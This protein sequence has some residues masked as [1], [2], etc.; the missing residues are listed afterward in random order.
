MK[1]IQKESLE[2]FWKYIREY[3]SKY[4]VSWKQKKK[5]L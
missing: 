4:K 3:H 2:R 1:S 5:L